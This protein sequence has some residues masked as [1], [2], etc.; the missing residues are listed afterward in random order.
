MTRGHWYHIAIAVSSGSGA[1]YLDGAVVAAFSTTARPDP[2]GSL[3]LGVDLDAT[4]MPTEYFEGWLDEVTVHARALSSSEVAASVCYAKPSPL[5]L[6][7]HFRFNDPNGAF[8]DVR[9]QNHADP[10]AP[11]EL[12]ASTSSVWNATTN[13]WAGQGLAGGGVSHPT[14][15]FMGAPWFPATVLS[16]AEPNG[17]AA[18]PLGSGS[19]TLG[20]VNLASTLV[21]AIGGVASTA[22]VTS[23]V[24]ASVAVGAIE[25]CNVGNV[26]APS[27]FAA[28][29]NA[30]SLMAT[31]FNAGGACGALPAGWGASSVTVTREVLPADIVRGLVCH[32]TFAGGEMNDLS[33]NSNNAVNN[34][35]VATAGK[36]LR[37]DTAYSLP[38]AAAH[39]SIPNCV[40][41]VTVAAWLKV[42]D[43][44]F[45]AA[46]TSPTQCATATSTDAGAVRGVWVF[47]AGVV[48]NTSVM[49]VYA[50]VSGQ[51][52]S[53]V[54]APSPKVKAF[55]AAALNNHMLGG[56]HAG[57]FTGAVDAVWV[58][59]RVLCAAELL[60]VL[61]SQEFA[62]RTVRQIPGITVYRWGV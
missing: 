54:S 37:D 32:Y 20:G 23:D 40:G 12:V 29:A 48:T 57:G 58:Y 24:S 46:S 61:D 16:A 18:V 42:D 47:Y 21:V 53:L 25:S 38:S 50:G 41:G 26:G 10:A 28:A 49:N 39:I 6:A 30:A 14:Y 2:S 59:S 52:L 33:G 3:V 19:L 60:L 17:A 51:S 36:N 22:S 34:A 31:N 56:A 55:L 5:G 13:T 45:S 4:G 43:E 27:S 8:P 7:V 35:A 15:E 11:G 1:L 44:P 9:V 62:L